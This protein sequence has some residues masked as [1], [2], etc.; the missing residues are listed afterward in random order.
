MPKSPS[1]WIDLNKIGHGVMFKGSKGFI[2]AD[3]GSRLIIPF[4]NTAD[5]TY[6]EPRT[7]EEL[8][9]DL[10]N[11]QKQWTEACRNGKPSETACNFEYSANMIE[12]MALG[13]VAFRAG[14]KL[15]YDGQSG[16]ITNHEK[17]NQFLTKPYREGWTLN[18]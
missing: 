14:E 3:F 1:N 15:D 16:K 6:Y 18:G 12:T 7:E 13:L 5:L 8:L 4:G 11:F 10:G 2:V 9:P 17:S